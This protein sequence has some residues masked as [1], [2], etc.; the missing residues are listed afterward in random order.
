LRIVPSSVCMKM[1]I[2][3]SQGSQRLVRGSSKRGAPWKP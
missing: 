2:A 3:T 1:A